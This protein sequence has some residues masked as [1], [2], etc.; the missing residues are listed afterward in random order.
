MAEERKDQPTNGDQPQEQQPASSNNS[1]KKALK[2]V[3]IIL[4]VLVVLGILGTILLGLFFQKLGET[5]FEKA[6]DSNIEVTDDGVNVETD[7]GSFSSQAELPDDFPDEVPLFEPADI[8]S[9][10]SQKREDAATYSAS[11]TTG[12]DAQQVK[13]FYK[14]ELDTGGW[15]TISTS[16]FNNRTH[17]QAEHGENIR[18][19]VAITDS[20]EESVRF[21]VS[22][23]VEE[24]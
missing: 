13:E 5:A 1:N 3:L 23:N 12:A 15:K 20:D 19:Q 22:V 16:T 2:I 6:T 9:S 14:R 17:Y 11:F 4:A 7:E 10:T 21:S 24:E 18:A 8:M